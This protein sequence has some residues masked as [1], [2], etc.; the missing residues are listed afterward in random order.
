MFKSELY[1]NL[2]RNNLSFFFRKILMS[3]FL[4]RLKANYLEKLHGYHSF[5]LWIPIALS[6]IYFF[7]LVLTWRKTFLL[8]QHQWN[9][10]W[11]FARKHD[12]LTRENNMICSH[13]KITSCGYEFHLLLFNSISYSYAARTGEISSWTLED[14]I[15]IHTLG[16]ACNILYLSSIPMFFVALFFVYCDY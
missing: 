9:A 14:R 11:A 15:H 6:E 16:L 1:G 5:S 8:Y 10:R 4:L 7:R 2:Q 3:V 13:V 12:I